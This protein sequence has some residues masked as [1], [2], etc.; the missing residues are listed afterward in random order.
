MPFYQ[1]CYGHTRANFA[2]SLSQKIFLSE[3]IFNIFGVYMSVD[4]APFITNAPAK[5]PILLYK[6]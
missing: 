1:G 4:E 5:S 2:H 6:P 3:I